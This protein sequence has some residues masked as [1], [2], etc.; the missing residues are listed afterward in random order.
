MKVR[1]FKRARA[2]FK[3]LLG[4][5]ALA[6]VTCNYRRVM[7]GLMPRFI[8]FRNP[9]RFTEKVLWLKYNHR[10]DNASMMADKIAVRDFVREVVGEDCLIPLVGTYSRLEDVKLRTYQ[11][12]LLSSQTILQGMYYLEVGRLLRLV[13]LLICAINGLRSTTTQCLESINMKISAPDC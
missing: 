11:R 10:F 12:N 13:T 9:I 5:K 6:Q 7:A 4:D 1:V 8:N 2:I 3:R